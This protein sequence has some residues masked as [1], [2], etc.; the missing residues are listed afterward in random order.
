MPSSTENRE[1]KNGKRYQT[2]IERTT[3]DDGSTKEN[4][5]WISSKNVEGELPEIQ[6][7]TQEAVNEQIRGFI[8]PLTHQL[9]E[10][11][12]LVQ[13]MTTTRHPNHYPRTEFGTTSG[14]ATPQF[15]MVTGVHRTWHRRRSMTSPDSDDETTYREYDRRFRPPTPPEMTAP[16]EHLPDAITTLP[17]RIH[18]NNPRLLQMQVP[19]FRGM[20]H[21]FCEFEHL[22]KVN[23]RPMNRRLAEEAKLLHFQSLFREE[24]IEL[25]QS[26]TITTETKLNDELRI[27]KR[28]P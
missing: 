15:D 26:L 20:K 25:Y 8:A 23:L 24:A 10:L 7:L 14:T 17:S 4:A 19:T 18:P 11:T 16:Y 3:S 22:Q 1:L 28:W 27:Y 5:I 13:A 2:S 6:K 21:N 12:R 9:E